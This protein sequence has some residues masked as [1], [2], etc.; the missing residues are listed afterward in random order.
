MINDLP[1][2]QK[3]VLISLMELHEKEVE[4]REDL[5]FYE[6][7]DVACKNV[8]MCMP[9]ANL[10]DKTKDEIH[11][12][13][14]NMI[15]Q[16]KEMPTVFEEKGYKPWLESEKAN[17][18]WNNRE[19][20]YR[21]LSEM[22]GWAPTTIYKSIDPSTDIILD[23]MGNPKC[24]MS[25]VK[26]GLVI[27]DVQSGKTA[28]YTGLI[29]KAI[30]AGYK[31]II[32]LAGQQNDLRAQ[33]QERLDKEVLGYETGLNNTI[34]NGERIGVGKINKDHTKIESLTSRGNDG[35]LKKS[36]GVHL[37]NKNGNPILAV[38]K[39]NT[40]VLKHL[41][42]Y[43]NK[44]VNL[45][46]GKI[47]IPVLIIDD[48]VDQASVNTNNAEENPTAINKWVR[49]IIGICNR[50]SYVGYTATPYA[51]VLIDANTN[52]E[53]Y[54]KDLFPKD[55]IIVLP[56]PQ[57]YCGVKEFF[58]DGIDDENDLVV[59]VNDVDQLVDYEVI[60]NTLKLKSYDEITNL[61]DSL[62]DA[63]DDFIIASAVRRARGDIT[64]NG[65]M[66]HIAAYK[67]PATS[68]RDLLDDRV[69]FLKQEFKFDNK[70]AVK[71]YKRIWQQ[72]FENVSKNRGV[73]GDNWDDIQ[74]QLEAVFELLKVKLLNGDSKDV[75]DYTE[76]TQ[77]E[78]IAVGGNKLS[79]G[80][81]LE[82]LM[83]SYYLRDPRAYD[84]AMQMGRWFGYKKNYID[85]C[86]IYS[87]PDL[88]R[89]F[90]YIMDASNRLREDITTMNNKKLTPMEF[91]LKILSHPSMIPTSNLKMRNSTQ[92]KIS[93][94]GQ[95]QETLRYNLNYVSKNET[96]VSEF[97]NDLESNDSIEK[98]EYLNKY[99]YRNVKAEEV[100]DLLD[101]YESYDNTQFG[102]TSRWAKYI[103]TLN[104]YGEL[105][106]WT[107]LLSG[108]NDKNRNT[109]NINNHSINKGRHKDLESSKQTGYVRAISNPS[110]FKFF[111]KDEEL[112]TQYTK[113]Y[114]KGDERLQK[115]F[116]P[117]D[118][119]LAIYPFDIVD[120]NDNT[121]VIAANLLGLVFWFPETD[122][123]NSKVD[124]VV[125]SVYMSQ[126]DI[127]EVYDDEK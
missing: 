20:Y 30:D 38:V 126:E 101:Q 93:F 39:K 29:N 125:N 90:L 57:N 4:N 18:K 55:F 78:I 88:I 43:I 85:L 77:S 109:I 81:T 17:I 119:F 46:N 89:N 108:T 22:K 76:S 75:I 50:V 15:N 69:I 106:N 100:L 25:F 12:E 72:R 16:S 26:K 27:G 87:Q 67:K 64:H 80:I 68:L 102:D 10:D 103:H 114:V 24:E 23:H 51:N 118:G 6:K 83:I 123:V 73:L 124:Y 33:T 92:I 34:K 59:E 42:E 40:S 7:V 97:I 28:N 111:F 5:S 11:A 117:K 45:V 54:G 56:T 82:G 74:E 44:P 52:D 36:V 107:I 48:E 98:E 94:G 37:V 116:T 120:K 112:R 113:G 71:R 8:I 49:E 14:T 53:L 99:I 79:R 127:D 110:D 104:L 32:V 61:S 1:D 60:D 95:R 121:K 84:T 91:G 63:V 65:M 3:R 70:N 35:D 21:Y 96:T 58:G 105:E 9:F 13:L 62:L 66:V 122:N 31:L 86:R 41:F 115:L 47:D 2:A 19:D